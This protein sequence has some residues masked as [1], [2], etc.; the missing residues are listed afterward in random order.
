M[1]YNKN[2]VLIFFL[3]FFIKLKIY[4]IVFLDYEV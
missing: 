4:Y 1:K 3:L 2:A